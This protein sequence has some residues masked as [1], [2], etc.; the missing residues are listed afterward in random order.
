MI[1]IHT[2]DSEVS[3]TTGATP[4]TV[5][6]PKTSATTTAG[7]TAGTTPITAAPPKTTGITTGATVPTKSE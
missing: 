5:V 6:T 1:G 4:S 3:S 7:T 2:F